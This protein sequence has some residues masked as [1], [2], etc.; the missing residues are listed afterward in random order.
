M[1]TQQLT[2]LRITTRQAA[3]NLVCGE[4]LSVSMIIIPSSFHV[5]RFLH[6]N[7]GIVSF[8]I[9]LSTKETEARTPFSL[10]FK[11][12]LMLKCHSYD[13]D[14]SVKSTQNVENE[15]K[16]AIHFSLKMYSCVIAFSEPISKC[17]ISENRF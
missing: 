17:D 11:A 13:S 8:D 3:L 14:F 4:N 12:V 10:E 9:Q 6:Q 15:G 7:G 1:A 5:K 16:G 2:P